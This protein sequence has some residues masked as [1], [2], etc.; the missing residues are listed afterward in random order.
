[1]V[2]PFQQGREDRTCFMH[3]HSRDT[4]FY[5]HAVESIT[6]PLKLVEK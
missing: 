1:M 3:F 5:G 4:A 2:G 6:M